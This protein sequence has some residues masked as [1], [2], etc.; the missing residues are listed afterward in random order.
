MIF[1]SSFLYLIKISVCRDFRDHLVQPLYSIRDEDLDEIQIYIRSW[2][3]LFEEARLVARFIVSSSSVYFLL[4]FSTGRLN[5]GVLHCGTMTFTT[6][7]ILYFETR[8]CS[9][10]TS[11]SFNLPEFF[12]VLHTILLHLFHD[13]FPLSFTS[14]LHLPFILFCCL[15]FATVCL[16]GYSYPNG[17]RLN[18]MNKWVWTLRS[19]TS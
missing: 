10:L 11:F 16:L 6:L 15:F 3:K 1:Y 8:S 5:P 17:I 14:W 13:S 7:F 2:S 19:W 18:R 4:F 9:G 12:I